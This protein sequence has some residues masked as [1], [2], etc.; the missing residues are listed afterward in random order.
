MGGSPRKAY[1]ADKTHVS[2]QV[3]FQNDCQQPCGN[4][5]WMV[6]ICEMIHTARFN[7]YFIKKNK[8]IICTPEKK[9]KERIVENDM[10]QAGLK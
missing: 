5:V 9:K 3:S 8:T 10:G 4:Y 6:L 2:T 1:R 7:H